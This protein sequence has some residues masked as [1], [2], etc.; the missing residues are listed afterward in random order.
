MWRN[1][2]KCTYMFMLPL[3]NLVC[4]GLTLNVNKANYLDSY[5]ISQIDKWHH[6]LIN[7]YLP[8]CIISKSHIL[9]SPVRTPFHIVASCP[10]ML[11]HG[12]RATSHVDLGEGCINF[13]HY[14]ID[15]QGN[16][17]Q[18]HIAPKEQRLDSKRMYATTYWFV[19][20][21]CTKQKTKKQLCAKTFQ[22]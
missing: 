15:P 18:E 10:L 17:H 2:I 3:K 14:R 16:F 13:P 19:L 4:K 5:T 20:I 11:Y 8:S 21:M 6:K 22:G 9:D 12:H 1:D 7:N